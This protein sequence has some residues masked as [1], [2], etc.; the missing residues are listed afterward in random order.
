MVTAV[1]DVMCAMGVVG[2]ALVTGMA[3]VAHGGIRDG[4]RRGARPAAPAYT[5]ERTTPEGRGRPG[6]PPRAHTPH[7][8]PDQG[9]CTPAR[10][11]ENES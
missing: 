5:G 7:P 3:D 2:V 8:R 4:R 6:H 10:R 11:A 1:V 9:V